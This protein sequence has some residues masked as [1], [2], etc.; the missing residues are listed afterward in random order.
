MLKRS[1]QLCHKACSRS[2]RGATFV[3]VLIALVI[4]AII[5]AAVP[6]ALIFSTKAVFAAKEQTMAESL[7][8]TQ[9]EYIKRCM[10]IPAT[11]AEPD[12]AYAVVPVP[13]DTYSIDVVAVAID[14]VDPEHQPLFLGEDEGIQEITVEVY[15]VDRLVLATVCY[16]VDR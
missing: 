14:P 15:H 3:E 1:Q 5:V 10:Y 6:P 11:G 7:T 12:P 4:L 8:R 2:S 16:K 9:M 13:D